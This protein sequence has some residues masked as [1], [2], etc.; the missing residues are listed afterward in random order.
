VRDFAERASTPLRRWEDALSL[1]VALFILPLFVLTNAGV[2]FYLA[3]FI[4]SLQHPTGLG[5][6]SGLVLGN[7]SAFL[8]RAG[9]ACATK[10]AV[11]PI[12][13]IFNMLLASHL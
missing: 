6:I 9:W 13:L 7:L 8:V 1:P 4:E 11:Y 5:I 2:P 3:S 10:L 12:V